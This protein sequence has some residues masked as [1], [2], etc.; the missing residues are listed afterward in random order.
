MNRLNLTQTV[1]S[2]SLY[3][4]WSFL[5]LGTQLELDPQKILF[6]LRVRAAEFTLHNVNS[7]YAKG[8]D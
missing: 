5:F 8:L 2:F 7:G 4:S 3:G 6:F 1:N